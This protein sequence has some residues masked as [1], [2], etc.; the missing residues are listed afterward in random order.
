MS[1]KKAEQQ[2]LKLTNGQKVSKDDWLKL[3]R[4]SGQEPAT[5]GK[6]R[7]SLKEYMESILG[8]RKADDQKR[9]ERHERNKRNKREGDSL[10]DYIRDEARRLLPNVNL[11]FVPPRWKT[12]RVKPDGNPNSM[13]TQLAGL[14]KKLWPNIRSIFIARPD[15]STWVDFIALWEGGSA[16]FDTKHTR[17]T[18]SAWT[19]GRQVESHQM[20]I[21]KDQ[22]VKGNA[23]FV[24]LRHHKGPSEGS[25]DYVIPV[26]ETGLPFETKSQVQWKAME[27]YKVPKDA[28]WFD[29]MHNWDA[30]IEQGWSSIDIIT[31]KR[32]RN[33]N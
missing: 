8:T 26:I 20:E 5:Q 14:L 19:F 25:S 23:A 29:S 28:I 11:I 6:K 12:W 4:Q 17:T 2:M 1:K 10:E 9:L 31:V 3:L 21:L 27:K 16:H 24:Y 22:H 30:F 7:G 32:L 13:K 15:G 18:K 33:Q